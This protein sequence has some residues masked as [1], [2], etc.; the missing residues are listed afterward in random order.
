MSA[1]HIIN[2]PN[3]PPITD[4]ND[5]PSAIN[6]PAI[7]QQWLSS[8]VS[9]LRTNDFA[10]LQEELFHP[11]SWWRDHLALQWDL[12]TIRGA[13][14]IAA[15]LQEHQPTAQLSA[16][17]LQDE[18]R[19]RPSLH[20]PEKEAGLLLTWIVSM[21]FFETRAYAVY[22]SLQELKGFEE[23]LGPRR[24]YGTLNSMP[25][26]SSKGTWLERRKRQVEFVD[27]EPQVLV[28][29]AGQSGLN[30]G[31]RLQLLGVS[32]LIIDKNE[33]IGDNWRK[34]Y[35][36]LVTHDPVEFTHMAYLPFPKNWPQ[37]TPKDKL[38]DWFEAYANLMELNVWTRTSIQ[39]AD[40]D[41][42]AGKWTVTV[43]RPDGFQVLH[44]RHL[45]WCTGHSGEPKIPSFPGQEDF[46]GVVYHGSQ[47][48][49]ASTHNNVQGKKV[50]V[51]GTGNSGHDIAENFYENGAEVTMLQR[52]GTPPT[53]QADI[54][55]ESLPFPVQFAL[56]VYL[57]KRISS[58][59]ASLLSGL[60][61]AGFKIYKGVD[62]SGIAR[63]YFTRGGGY[64]IDV[65]CSQLII[66][67]KIKVKHCP[68]GI[69]RFTPRGIVL[70]D[71]EHTELPADIVVLATGYDNM[72]T[73]VRKVLGDKVADRC[74]DVWDLDEEGELNAIWRPSG[75]PHFWFMG[76]N[77]ALCRIYSKFL[78][79]Q[80][81][82]IEEGLVPEDSAAAAQSKL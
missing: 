44:P 51:V 56:N 6:P 39:S 55:S 17:K 24:V 20:E 82:A 70:N 54:F 68:G 22:T 43:S 69:A 80:I 29:G 57:T 60:E 48:Q 75:H 3:T 53:D 11:D 8:L 40:Y 37:F 42:D 26:G 63:L 7:A 38:A 10:R 4:D 41:D 14:G 74:K 46:Q 1:S 79:L 47:H 49:D 67:G 52:S 25:G 59:D 78:A 13:E 62:D 71:E 18:G 31:A 72:R 19:Y 65:G 5:N 23:P 16:L 73:T 76:G 12:R 45:V 33:R 50:I 77:L 15:F 30:L 2:L 34:R 81:K 64:Y 66:D 61:R 9:V 35:R 27:E 32:T 58:V 36:T 21:F 28:V